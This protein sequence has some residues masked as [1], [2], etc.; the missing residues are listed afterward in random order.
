VSF[1]QRRTDPYGY[2][3]GAGKGGK[4]VRAILRIPR[5]QLSALIHGMTSS[6]MS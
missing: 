3:P 5:P 6:T 1:D 2:G 4:G